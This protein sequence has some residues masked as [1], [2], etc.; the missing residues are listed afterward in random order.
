MNEKTADAGIVLSYS[1]EMK[2]RI[3]SDLRDASN[4]NKRKVV[5]LDDDPTG[6]Q[7]VHDVSVYTDWSE[8]SLTKGFEEDRNLFFILTNSRKVVPVRHLI[9]EH[10]LALEG[11]RS[12]RLR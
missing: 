12:L 3:D 5:V 9:R 7:T 11:H 4:K 10:A 2:D 8:D 1:Q 6:I